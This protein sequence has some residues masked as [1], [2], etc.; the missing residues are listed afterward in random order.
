MGEASRARAERL[1]D[2]PRFRQAHLEL[3]RRALA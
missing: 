1:F 3:Y 2:L